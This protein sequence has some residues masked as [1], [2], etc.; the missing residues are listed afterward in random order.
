MAL[1]L[2]SDHLTTVERLQTEVRHARLEYE[3]AKFTFD[4]ILSQV[5]S[6]IPHPDGSFRIQKASKAYRMA[7]QNFDMALR[8][9]SE[10]TLHGTLP[11]ADSTPRQNP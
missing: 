4:R 9:F 3:A 6:G 8:R 11:A 5:P 7:L 2:Q 10:F 1:Q